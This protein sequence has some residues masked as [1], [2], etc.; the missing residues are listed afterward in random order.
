MLS[1]PECCEEFEHFEE[2]QKLL[3]TIPVEPGDSNAM[4]ARFDLLMGAKEAEHPSSAAMR[5]RPRIRP[6]KVVLVSLAA[7]AVII[8]A[9]LGV[10]QA[11]KWVSVA[12]VAPPLS[13]PVP[14]PSPKPVAVA[15]RTGAISGQIRTANGEMPRKIRVAVIAVPKSGVPSLEIAVETSADGKYQLDNIP[16]GQYYVLA[17]S[18]DAPTYYPGSPDVAGATIVSIQPGVVLESIDFSP[19]VSAGKPTPPAVPSEL[20]EITGRDLLADGS[21]SQV[22]VIDVTLRLDT[23]ERLPYK[24]DTSIVFTGTA[25]APPVAASCVVGNLFRASVPANDS[26]ALT[27]SNLA[28]GYAVQSI[29]DASMTDLLHGDLFTAATRPAVPSRIVITLTKN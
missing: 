8:A 21:P 28:P 19:I 6:L 4:R 11:V 18:A 3:Q 10:R 25:G 1:C 7:I 5:L 12:T 20:A 16:T 2:M 29:V 14:E 27:V 23:G 17:S 26:Y 24:P 13:T 22:V 9:A 15:A